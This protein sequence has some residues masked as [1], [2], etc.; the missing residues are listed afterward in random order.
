M[1]ML[2]NS[3]NLVGEFGTLEFET[4]QDAWNALVDSYRFDDG[5]IQ[6][7]K[8]QLIKMG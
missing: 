4:E 1:I 3:M 2:T 6:Y 7:T 8:E 5:R